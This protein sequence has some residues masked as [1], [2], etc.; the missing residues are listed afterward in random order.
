MI[1]GS[2]GRDAASDV[3]SVMGP[4]GDW[5]TF[6]TC[7]LAPGDVQVGRWRRGEGAG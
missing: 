4:N 5:W 7:H 6:D 3:G 2:R 1:E